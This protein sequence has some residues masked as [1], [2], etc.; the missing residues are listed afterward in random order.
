MRPK[1]SN[2]VVTWEREIVGGRMTRF[3]SDAVL[4]ATEKSEVENKNQR[5]EIEVDAVSSEG[6]GGKKNDVYE[7]S[8]D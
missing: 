8:F 2:D 4:F 1:K 7:I 6:F 3:K 5:I